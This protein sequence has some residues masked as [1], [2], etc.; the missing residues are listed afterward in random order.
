MAVWLWL[1]F[2]VTCWTV[3]SPCLMLRHVWSVTRRSTTTSHI[4]SKTSTGCE[5]W[6][7]Y[8]FEGPYSFFAAVTTWHP[9][10]SS[11]ISNGLTNRSRCDDYGSALNSGWL[12]LERESKPRVTALSVWWLLVRVYFTTLPF[13]LVLVLLLCNWSVL[14]LY[15]Y[16]V[17]G[18]LRHRA[19]RPVIGGDL[20]DADVPP[21]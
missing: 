5:F 9:H 1:V 10:T 11:A 15:S 18:A 19:E 20:A 4:F 14:H 8:N 6:K 2:P 17:I 7:E 16:S 21:G 12:Y 3:C 13:Y